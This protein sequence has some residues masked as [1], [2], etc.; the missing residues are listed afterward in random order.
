MIYECY[1]LA[2][3]KYMSKID[4]ISGFLGAGKTTLIKKL[5]AE[6]YQNEKIVLIENE[7]GEI[8]IDGTFLKDSGVTINEMNSG[9]I[10]CSLV[11]DFETSLKEVLDTYHPDRVIIEPSGV[12]KLSDVIKAVSTI[13]SDEMELDNFI[14][15]VDA[16]KCRMYTKNFG[17]FYNNQVEHASLIVLSRSQ[18]LTEF[19]L[20]ECLDILKGLNDHSPIITTAWD[21]LNGLDIINACEV[22]IQEK[23]LHEHDHECCG[24][25][26]HHHDHDH[27]C[28]CG[29]HHHHADEVFNSIGFDTVKKY[30]EVE[31]SDILKKKMPK[32][33][34]IILSGYGE[35][36]YAK[37]AIKI[38]V[39]DYLTKPVT[40]EQ[41]LEALNKVKQKLDKKKRQEEDI[42]KIQKNIKTQMK[43]MRYQ[44]FGNLIRGKIS[45]SKL[46]EQGN[47]LGIDLM[48][49]A[50]NFM[51]FK[52]FSKNE[53]DTE[54]VYDLRT[55]EDAIVEEV[56]SQFENM[57][58]FHRVTEGYILMIKAQNKEETIQVAKD[59]VAALT[60]R[61]KKEKE[62]QWFAG[63]GRAVE[64]LHN[65]SES[66]DSAS[67]A[68]AY[69]Y[70]SSGNEAVFFDKLDNEKIERAEDLQQ[71]DFTKVNSESLE[72]FLK[73][74]KEE[75]VHLFVEDYTKTLGKSNMD[76]FMFCQYMLINIQVGVMKFVE[77]MG[78]EKANIDRTFKDYKQQIA[79]VSTGE[80]AAEYIEELIRQA[81]RMRNERLGKKHSSLITEAKE[82]IVKN[83][84]EETLS[85]SDVAD[86]VGLSSSHFSTTFKQETGKSFVEFLTSVRMDKAKEMLCFTDMKASQISYEVGYKDPHYFSYLFKKTQG[87]T[88]SEYRSRRM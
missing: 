3:V 55:K 72:E 32:I 61:M 45:V 4:I 73:N 5:I 68:F 13:N 59:Y 50:Y 16:K 63:I 14:T 8:G 27:E 62:L 40:G 77:K 1:N 54:A 25:D 28:G 52:I 44:F 87:C 21:K 47:E 22:N 79:A 84:Q 34:I 11:G 2:E 43:N 74:G 48:A 23:L 67:K 42:K 18:D 71:V 46:M 49:P 6:A 85:L 53:N 19:Q 29:H 30:N 70:Q 31:L 82:F 81:I 56:S 38:G 35:F 80:K 58:V 76:S 64:R 20:K 17:E 60:K 37:E 69:Q 78:V 83:Y 39:T 57:I 88:P 12:G 15:V 65:L 24:H 10:C 9:C 33:Q 26:H 51:L 75:A 41:L 36:D 86:Q 66:Y 7:F